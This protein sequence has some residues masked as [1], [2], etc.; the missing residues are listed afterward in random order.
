MEMLLNN[1]DTLILIFVLA[2][3]LLLFI[4]FL[5]AQ[6]K[7]F[8]AIAPENRKLAPSDV[9]YQLIPL[10][11]LYWMFVVVNRLSASFALEFDRLNIVRTELYPTRAIGM[12]TC[13]VYF[14]TVLP[15]I[16]SLASF[17]W[18]ICFIIYWVKINQIKKEILQNSDTFLLDAERDLLN[19]T[20][21]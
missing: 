17:A 1:A 6:Y 2:V 5:L 16:K 14:A 18:I 15:V 13:I 3:F 10:F 12:A 9:W 8:A 7:A 19:Q 21:D 20:P 4:L 11:N